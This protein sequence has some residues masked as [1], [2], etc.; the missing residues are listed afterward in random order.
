MP[1]IQ[2]VKVVS[3][4]MNHPVVHVEPIL[5]G[6]NTVEVN[7]VDTILFADWTV[8]IVLPICRTRCCRPY[9]L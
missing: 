6:L 8:G 5:V 7:A 9:S 3:L 1:K 4:A 2:A